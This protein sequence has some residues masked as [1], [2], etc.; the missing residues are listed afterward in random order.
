MPVFLF[1][2]RFWY[3][4]FFAAIIYKIKNLQKWQNCKRKKSKNVKKIIKNI[5]NV[6]ISYKNIDTTMVQCYYFI[7]L[8]KLSSQKHS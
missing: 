2:Y 5:N 6:K 4:N 3:S 8:K 1:L 7:E